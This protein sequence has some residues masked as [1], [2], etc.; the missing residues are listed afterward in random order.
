M[1]RIRIGLALGSGIARGWAH[2]GVLKALDKL[3]IVPDMI[4]G[5]SI[6]AL[7][8]GFYLGGHA[9]KLEQWARRLTKFRMLRYF[10]LS[11]GGGMISG[12]KLFQEAENYIGDTAIDELAAPFVAVATDLRTGHEVWLREGR[13]V[14]AMRASLS[15]PGVF[16]PV[17]ADGRWLLDGAL[18]NPVPVSVCRALGAQMVI[19]VN[20]SADIM[21]RGRAVN[22]DAMTGAIG[23]DGGRSKKQPK[24]ANGEEKPAEPPGTFDVMMESLNIVQDRI[25][26]GRLAGDPPDVS[27][28]PRIGHIG[29]LDFHRADELITEGVDAVERALPEIRDAIAIFSAMRA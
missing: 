29:L 22:G 18:V 11:L 3:G 2:L 28:T 9:D 8:G 20:L 15:L 25:A 13:V 1:R 14:D 19:A 16:K 21:G 27:I 23:P 24:Q 4:A 7:V 26:R 10:N 5:T 12:D 6:G 17:Y